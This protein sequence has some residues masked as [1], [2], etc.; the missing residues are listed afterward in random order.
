[1]ILQTNTS[2]RRG[3]R[4]TV[5]MKRQC[6]RRKEPR[7]RRKWSRGHRDSQGESTVACCWHLTSSPFFTLSPRRPRFYLP[8]SHSAHSCFISLL[9]SPLPSD[10]VQIHPSQ[11]AHPTPSLRHLHTSRYQVD[12]ILELSWEIGNKTENSP[13][14][15][16][17]VL[18]GFLKDWLMPTPEVVS[19]QPWD[20]LNQNNPAEPFLVT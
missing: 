18:C 9:W 14:L 20:T 2:D 1:M 3:R 8:E 11:Q 10:Q 7:H 16:C 12:S 17:F 19:L 5:N 15:C 4:E 13:F 6:Q